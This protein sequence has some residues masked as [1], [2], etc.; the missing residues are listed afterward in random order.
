MAGALPSS[1]VFDVNGTLSDLSPMQER[2]T[3][4][5]LPPPSASLWFATV[6]RDGFALAAAG[7][8]QPFSSL[9]EAAARELFWPTSAKRRAAA[10]PPR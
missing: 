10:R 1:V 4:R 6:L 9:A 7:A 8:F 5:G 3:R 2:F